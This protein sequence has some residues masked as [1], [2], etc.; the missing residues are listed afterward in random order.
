[1][2]QGPKHLSL[3]SPGV[4]VTRKLG[5]KAEVA[6]NRALRY[7]IGHPKWGLHH[8]IKALYT[9]VAR[10]TGQRMAGCSW[11]VEG[12]KSQVEE[13]QV[14]PALRHSPHGFPG[15]DET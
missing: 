12:P 6:L 3:V 9:L 13:S 2:Q 5:S 4:H 1:M 11:G 7:R 15:R 10:D 14:T 8:W